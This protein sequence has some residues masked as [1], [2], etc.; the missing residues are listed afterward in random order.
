[1]NPE[2]KKVTVLDNYILEIEF[3]N[4]QKG[5]FSMLPYLDYPIYAPL[6]DY[7]VF[8]DAKVTMGFIS[9]NDDIDMSP[10]TLYID[11]KMIA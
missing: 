6:K 11:S 7:S 5:Q 4:G 9:W 8:K 2:V 1:M 3:D 10:D